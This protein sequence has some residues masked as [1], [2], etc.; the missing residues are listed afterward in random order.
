MGSI[1]PP[2]I[3]A[4]RCVCKQIALLFANPTHPRLLLHQSTTPAYVCSRQPMLPGGRSSSG[5]HRGRPPFS[6]QRPACAGRAADLLTILR[7]CLSLPGRG[8]MEGGV[9][10]ITFTTLVMLSTKL[11]LSPSPPQIHF[12]RRSRNQSS[13]T[14]QLETLAPFGRPLLLRRPRPAVPWN[15]WWD[16]PAFGSQRPPEQDLTPRK[17]SWPARLTLTAFNLEVL[18]LTRHTQYQKIELIIIIFF[19]QISSAGDSLKM[20]LSRQ[21]AF[22]RK[23]CF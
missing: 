14:S 10:R 8:A 21:D 5:S 1:G 23:P 3:Q 18:E 12:G 4:A 9:R 19:L 20:A 6:I 16:R 11:P 13:R 22:R 15:Q 17:P 2:P 7:I